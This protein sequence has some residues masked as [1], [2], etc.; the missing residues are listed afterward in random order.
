MNNDDFKLKDLM[1][2]SQNKNINPLTGRK[3]KTNGPMY[4]KLKKYYELMKNNTYGMFSIGPKMEDRIV[5][6]QQNQNLFAGVYD[7]HGGNLTSEFIKQ[8]IFLIYSKIKSHI[9]TEKLELTYRNLEKEFFDYFKLIQGRDFSGSTACTL[10]LTPNTIYI[11]NTGD[12]RCIIAEEGK[13]LALTNDHKPN[14]LIEKER[15]KMNKE[16]NLMSYT[17]VYRIGGLAVSRVIGDFY[18]KNKVKSV[19]YRPDI[20]MAKRNE[21]QDFILLATDGLYDVMTN[22][23]IVN[24]VY[25]EMKQTYDLDLVSK[26]LVNY[27]IKIKKSMDDVSV[28][29]ILL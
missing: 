29:I 26:R 20:F 22:Q 8:N 28:I 3:I 6:Q 21:Y 12:S 13:A 4:I 14:E 19:I 1:I 10:V 15:I 17:G 24:F 11:A 5:F 27:A 7:G 16:E 25:K 18:I 23:E 9:I 2:W